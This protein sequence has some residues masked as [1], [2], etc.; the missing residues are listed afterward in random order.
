MFFN[1]KGCFKHYLIKLKLD[2][3]FVNLLVIKAFR[4]SYQKN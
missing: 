3:Y 4:D 2:H 1:V